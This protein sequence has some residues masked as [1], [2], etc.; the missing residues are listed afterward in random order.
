M[1]REFTNLKALSPELSCFM[2]ALGGRKPEYHK[3][4]QVNALLL[5]SKI[6]Y[7]LSTVIGIE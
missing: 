6:V 1:Q 3:T 7:W 5:T 4:A 2:A